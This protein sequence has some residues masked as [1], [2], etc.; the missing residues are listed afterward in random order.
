MSTSARPGGPNAEG[1][2]CTADNLDA[3]LHRA[4]AHFYPDIDERG[5][6]VI[7]NPTNGSI[8]TTLRAPLYYAGISKVRGDSGAMVSKEGAAAIRVPLD[9]KDDSIGLP[10]SL[11][12]RGLTWFVIT[13]VAAAHV[14]R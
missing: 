7:W 10:V 13:Q 1:G 12:P 14:A 8:A 5:L 3:I 4:P 9:V 2:G 11:G 6:A